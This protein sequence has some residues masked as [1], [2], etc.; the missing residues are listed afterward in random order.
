M[1]S[2]IAENNFNLDEI[3]TKSK[4]KKFKEIKRTEREMHSV[5]D[6]HNSKGNR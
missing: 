1:K 5:N 4:I 6:H 3:M 2:S